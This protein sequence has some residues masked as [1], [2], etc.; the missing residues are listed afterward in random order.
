M[1]ASGLAPSRERARVLIMSG[2]VHVNGQVADKPG[3]LIH[4]AS[5]I[6]LQAEP[7]PYVS[8]GGIKLA[9]DTKSKSGLRQRTRASAPTNAP[10]A[11]WK[12][13]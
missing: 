13:G 1:I 10:L 2:S 5:R 8:R 11:T 7:I 9:G 4:P 12:R 3:A 6:E